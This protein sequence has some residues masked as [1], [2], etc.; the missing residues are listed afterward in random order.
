M[1]GEPISPYEEPLHHPFTRLTQ[2]LAAHGTHTVVTGLGGDEM[3]ALSQAE[4]PHKAVGELA[5]APAWI[6]S[7]ARAAGEYADDGAAPSAVVNSM[8]LLSLATTA[9]VL[10]RAGI[11]PMHPFTHPAL[12]RLGEQLPVDWREF[13]Q[14]Q[15]RQLASFGLGA[16][17]TQPGRR[18]SFA[19]V[20]QHALTTCAQ[21]LFTAM[22]REGSALFEHHLVDP[23]LLRSAVQRISDRHY[24]E[25]GDA[26]LLQV[27]HLHLAAQAFG[28]GASSYGR[29]GLTG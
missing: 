18:E 27:I 2:A 19:E 9:P 25:D 28:V 16:E 15:R 13:K 3:V 8:T 22:L 24:R 20:V 5:E 17:V 6:G 4:Y 1:R 21:P 10:L 12:I 11:W 26:Q 29:T 7:A 23:D 14:L